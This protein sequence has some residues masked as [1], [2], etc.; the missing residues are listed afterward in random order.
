M[1]QAGFPKEAQH[2]GS[3]RGDNSHEGLRAEW[4]TQVGGGKGGRK[5]M[6]NPSLKVMCFV[7]C[8]HE[9]SEE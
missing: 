5:L 4:V 6:P 3:V 2:P 9:I 8:L 7:H 1:G